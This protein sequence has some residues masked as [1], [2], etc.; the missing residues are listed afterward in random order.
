MPTDTRQVK[1][2]LL[3]RGSFTEEQAEDL[4]DALFEGSDPVVTQSLLRSEL[5]RVLLRGL[6][7]VAAIN[8]MFL[9]A[10]SFL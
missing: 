8:G 7:G 2:R 4:V 6:L 9:A 3:Q 5:N 10:A 1:Q